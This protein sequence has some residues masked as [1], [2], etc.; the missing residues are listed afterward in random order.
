MLKPQSVLSILSKDFR[1]WEAPINQVKKELTLTIDI[2]SVLYI[3]PGPGFQRKT[4]LTI[5]RNCLNAVHGTKVINA[6]ALG[7][8]MTICH[9]GHLVGPGMMWLYNSI[10]V[11]CLLPCIDEYSAATRKWLIGFYYQRPRPRSSGPIIRCLEAL[12]A[13]GWSLIMDGNHLTKHNKIG[14][15]SEYNITVSVEEKEI[16]KH[17]LR[18]SIRQY[19]LEQVVSNTR[20]AQSG[21]TRLPPREDFKVVGA[22]VFI[23][24]ARPL[25]MKETGTRKEILFYILT[26]GIY[27]RNRALRHKYKPANERYKIPS[28]GFFF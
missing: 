26:G 3:G 21:V 24:G 18:M 6:V 2:G 11:F 7:A 9:K 19:A 15:C 10:S 25:Y 22:G 17:D 14:N 27:T 4:G 23:E 16:F 12:E 5:R 1:L 13:I 20:W 8:A 28:H